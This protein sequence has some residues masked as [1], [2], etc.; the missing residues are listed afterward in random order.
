[1][2]RLFD[3]YQYSKVVEICCLSDD[4]RSLERGDMSYIEEKLTNLSIGQRARIALARALYSGK[5][6]LLLDNPLS[7]LDVRVGQ[8]IYNNLW[9]LCG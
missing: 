1:M 5:K 3:E 4:F 6:V 8:K 2:D 7:A 9:R